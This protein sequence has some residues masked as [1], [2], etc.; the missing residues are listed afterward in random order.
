V[1]VQGL[2]SEDQRPETRVPRPETRDVRPEGVEQHMPRRIT[3]NRKPKTE[4]PNCARAWQVLRLAHDRVARRLTSELGRQ[5]DLTI[6]DFDVLLHLRLHDEQEVRMQD[7]SGA[8]L[9]SQ[10][11]L[12]RLVSRLVERE[13][14]ERSHAADDGRA[15]LILLTSAGR[16]LADRAIEVHT[17]SVE[18]ELVSRLSECEQQTLL[19][20]LNRIGDPD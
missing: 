13:L 2:D 19:A 20:A 16:E 1:R 4:N 10:P 15:V 7:L 5:C 14:I 3:E 12:S 11:A 8:V 9:L 17:R 18:E 6:S